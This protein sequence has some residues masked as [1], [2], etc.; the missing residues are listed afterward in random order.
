VKK[1]KFMGVKREEVLDF[2]LGKISPEKMPAAFNVA[3]EFDVNLK[4]STGNTIQLVSGPNELLIEGENG[5]IRVNRGTLTGKPVEEIDKD[6][7]AKQEIEELMAQIYGGSRPAD[8]LGHMQNF[9]DCIRNGKPPVANVDDHVRAVNACHLANMALVT[10]RKV[11]YDPAAGNFGR[12]AEAN[13]LMSRKQRA[14]YA[15]EL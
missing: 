7:K 2:L 8:K 6:P 10:G 1:S 4:L 5:K 3:L 12:D 14:P 11:S 15:I 13:R 9:F